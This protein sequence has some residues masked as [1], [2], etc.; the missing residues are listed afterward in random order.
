MRPLC[1]TIENLTCFRDRQVIDFTG[2]QLFAIAGPTGAGKS[3]LLD[4]IIFALYR[5]VPRVGKSV[6]ELIA[7]GRKAMTVVFEFRAGGRDYRLTRS[8]KRAGG[9]A[10]AQLDQLLAGNEQP[11][12]EG[13]REVD[14]A[15]E[16][17]VG[18]KYDAFVQAVVLPQGDFAK[19]LRSAPGE[20]RT[21]LRDLLR[22][23]LYETMRKRARA[24]VD[25]CASDVSHLERRLE[26]DFAGVTPEALA[27]QRAEH[28]LIAAR[29]DVNERE[30]QARQQAHDSLMH[31]RALTIEREQ[32]QAQADALDR[33]HAM[34][35]QQVRALAAARRAA[36]VVPLA[37]AHAEQ[38]RA[39]DRARQQ[40]REATAKREQLAASAMQAR[41]AR[42]A[43]DARAAELPGYRAKLA[44]LDQA[45]GLLKP[46]AAARA[47]LDAAELDQQSAG[48]ELDA[49]RL[50]DEQRQDALRRAGESLQRAARA[51][52]EIRFDAS[53]HERLGEARQAASELQS[54]RATLAGQ[55]AELCAAAAA[56]DRKATALAESEARVEEA[57]QGLAVAAA[58]RTLAE[59]RLR[60]AEQRAA[61]AVLRAQLHVGEAC[62]VCDARIQRLPAA[63][64]TVATELDR[65][66]GERSRAQAEYDRAH[67]ASTAARQAAATAA[68]AASSAAEQHEL[69]GR[70]CAEGEVE[71]AAAAARLSGMAAIAA[72]DEPLELRVLAAWRASDDR[73]RQHEAAARALAGAKDEHHRRQLTA[74]EAAQ[75]REQWRARLAQI[76]VARERAAHEIAELTREIADL[77]GSLDPLPERDRLARECEQIERACKLAAEA[78]QAAA[79]EL[80]TI[81]ALVGDRERVADESANAAQQAHSALAAAASRAQ[82]GSIA[83]ALAAHLP[84]DRRERAEREIEQ[85]RRERDALGQRLAELQDELRDG[86]EVSEVQVRASREQLAAFEQALQC[87]R[88]QLATLRERVRSLAAKIETVRQ[89]A[90]EL[91]HERRRHQAHLQLAHDLGGDRLQAYVL[92]ETFRELVA[93][94]ST[95]LFALSHRYTLKFENE[96]FHVV[97][98]DNACERRRAETLSGGETFLAS[99]ALA[100]ELSEQVQRAAGAMLLDSLF[101]DEG[102][103][104][105]D[106]ETLETVASAIEALPTG[107]RM[108]G[109]ITHIAELTERLPAR[110]RVH[111]REQG[112][113]VVVLEQEHRVPEQQVVG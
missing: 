4:A 94:A 101:I 70:R 43:A 110:L 11:I 54:L 104:T 112:S 100:L 13:V 97:D 71:L 32:K 52:A 77:T 41:A 106:A 10:R 9:A 96:V 66:R 8:A 88:D 60:E 75:K 17:L 44:Q 58:A 28:E 37:Q 80:A 35:E 3:S 107:G 48:A 15:V 109:I 64:A 20:R 69:C 5:R 7:A 87:D 76:A 65:V 38:E 33:R 46:L 19:F 49:A 72:G 90:G 30:R 16:Q 21:I 25:R 6:S 57:E 2:L 42:E 29:I 27:E 68:V 22:L 99:L 59:T 51:L 31:R 95:R 74:T 78:G 39:L 56:R 113:S 18:L 92:D 81:D 23:S 62:P 1:L 14:A 34:I 93:G 50:G 73:R 102:F 85:H 67:Q 103:G 86:G 91:E 45:R 61:A 12:C 26:Q 40:L 79:R 111:K 47:R 24:I 89:I 105:L 63:V 83:E 84:A 55:T 36:D 82:F 53:E 108:V 98:H